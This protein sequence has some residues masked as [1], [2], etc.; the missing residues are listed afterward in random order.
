MFMKSNDID[1]G[2]DHLVKS[3]HKIKRR[4]V[5]LV[6]R[7]NNF[8][9]LTRVTKVAIAEWNAIKRQWQRCMQPD[10]KRLLKHQINRA[11]H[12]IADLINLERNVQ[13]NRTL[14]RQE[15]GAKKIW[16]LCKSIKNR[17]HLR[18]KY[19]QHHRFYRR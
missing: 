17:P 12:R 14:Q 6:S 16:R 13:R 7:H 1:I 9:C 15:T 3:I 19:K 10:R 8:I 2:I 5:L 4:S 18:F 11:N